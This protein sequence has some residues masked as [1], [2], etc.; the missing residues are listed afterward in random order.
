MASEVRIETST[1]G[2]VL[3]PPDHDGTVILYPYLSPL[4]AN[5]HRVT[6]PRRPP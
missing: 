4:Y 5:L 3:Y 2:P 1:V 6:S